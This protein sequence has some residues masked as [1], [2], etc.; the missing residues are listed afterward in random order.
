MKKLLA[1]AGFLALGF[2]LFVHEGTKPEREPFS[3]PVSTQAT[4]DTV[5]KAF[6]QHRGNF[7]AEG[8][9][10]VVRVL[11]DDNDGSRHQRFIVELSSGQSLLIAHN[12]DLA[13]RVES[14]RVGDQISFKGEYEWNDKGGVMHWTHRDP[15]GRHEPGWIRLNG[16]TYQ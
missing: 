8:A 16:K 13:P 12:I 10:K 1:V 2:V 15:A 6:A 7:V 4:E 3:S 9:G 14:L 11:A 5:A